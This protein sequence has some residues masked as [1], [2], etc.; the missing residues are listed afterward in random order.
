MELYSSATSRP[1]DEVLFAPGEEVLYRLCELLGGARTT[2]D[3]CV[4]T[5]S[6]DRITRNIIEAHRRGVSI[7]LI[8]DD[9]KRADQGSD[10]DTL[11]RAGIPIRTDDGEPHMHHKF[12]LFDAS[13]LATGSYNWT[14]GAT[15]NHENLLV[16]H[17]PTAVSRYAGAFNALWEHMVPLG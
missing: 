16:T 6:D 14:R 1:D 12:A 10:I 15:F 3:L 9:Q 2:I 13:I 5:I 17:S 7:R 4:F 11:A 8:T